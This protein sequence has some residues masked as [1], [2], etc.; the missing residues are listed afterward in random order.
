MPRK[1]K[2]DLAR[3]KEDILEGARKLLHS[4]TVA[5]YMAAIRGDTP[6]GQ[7]VIFGHM[8][9]LPP[10]HRTPSFRGKGGKK[11]P[12]PSPKGRPKRK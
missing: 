5:D 3:T 9:A 6:P 11:S 1:N 10:V 8:D 4:S 7:P 12:L 2:N